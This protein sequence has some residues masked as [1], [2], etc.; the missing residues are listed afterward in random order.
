[1]DVTLQFSINLT[2][3]STGAEARVVQAQLHV[4]DAD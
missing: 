2:P 1:M 4:V 3:G